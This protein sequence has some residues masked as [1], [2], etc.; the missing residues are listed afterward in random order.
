MHNNAPHYL[1]DNTLSKNYRT[2]IRSELVIAFTL[3]ISSRWYYQ[4]YGNIF[5]RKRR[6]KIN[7]TRRE[8]ERERGREIGQE[9]KRLKS[10]ARG[11][12]SRE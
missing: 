5:G 2:I 10:N 7:Y 9:R 4:F 8:E 3:L 1:Y 11:G 12:V 6:I